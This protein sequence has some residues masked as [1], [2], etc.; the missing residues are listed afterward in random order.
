MPPLSG[1]GEKSVVVS[2]KSEW[3]GEEMSGVGLGNEKK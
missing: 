1:G 3:S 2:W